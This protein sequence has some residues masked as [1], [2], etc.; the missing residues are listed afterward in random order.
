MAGFDTCRNN[1]ITVYV[2]YLFYKRTGE[3]YIK[4]KEREIERDFVQ[5]HIFRL[6]AQ[7]ER[8]RPSWMPVQCI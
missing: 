8:S 3:R 6:R 2:D 7:Q 1:E 5:R 4:N